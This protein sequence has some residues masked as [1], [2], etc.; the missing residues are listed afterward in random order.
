MLRRSK[1]RILHLRASQFHGGPEKQILHHA[2]TASSSGQE[3]WVGSF[4]DGPVRPEFL[5]RAERMGLPTLEISSGRFDPRT[6]LELAQLLRQKDISLL[7]S[8]GYKAN[9]VG[10]AACRLTGCAQIAFARGW[11]AENW[12]IKLYER[13]D[14]LV[15]HWTDWVVCVSRLLADELQKNRTG[16]TPPV[17]IPNAALFPFENLALPVNR[18]PL[19]KVLG[20]RQDRFFVC[21]AGRLSPE[22]GHRYLVQAIPGLVRRIP[23]LSLLFLGEGRERQSL[24][25]EVK[26]LGVQKYVVFAGF[27][28]DV[29]S[30]IQACDLLVNPS[31]TEGMPNVVLEAMALGTPVVATNVGGVP[32]LIEHLESGLLIAP[33]DPKALAAAIHGIFANPAEALRLA[34]NA[35]KRLK[36]Y[37]PARQS[38]RLQQLY[39]RALKVPESQLA[40]NSAILPTHG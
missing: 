19:R 20:L 14:R 3:I 25:E 37:S 33:A 29:R 26:R 36:E 11:T 4:R 7:C 23:Q 10:W 17:V 15:L 5:A 32:D 6:V 27:Q 8:H 34:Q 28:K 31:L 21:A 24:A 30:W 22:K 40:G 39:A 9:L 12:R 35:Q 1:V 18:L 38:Q 16:R 13:L 2:M